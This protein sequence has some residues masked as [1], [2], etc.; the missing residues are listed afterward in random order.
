MAVE[1]Q[2]DLWGRDA[3]GQLWVIDY[4]TGASEYS[5][6]AIRQLRYYAEALVAAG[7]A[8]TTA[9]IRLAALYPF[10]REVRIENV[11]LLQR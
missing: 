9:E 3:R 1:G 4:K 2:I 6:K 11:Y 10:S 5:E 8:R 7:V